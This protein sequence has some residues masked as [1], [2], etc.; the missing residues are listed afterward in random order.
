MIIL[1]AFLIGVVWILWNAA[2][3][4][5]LAL[6]RHTSS[7]AVSVL[8]PLRNEEKRVPL[9]IASLQQL[10]YDQLEIL[11][12]DDDS[13]DA[14]AAR[15]QVAIQDDSRFHLLRGTSLPTGWKGKP[16]ACLQLAKTARGDILLFI[17]ADVTLAHNT[18]EAL[19]AT[20]ARLQADA[21]S[22]FPRFI[23]DSFLENVLTPL[24]HFFIY[25]HL[26]IRVANA[27]TFPA[28]TA[29]SGA[30][31]AMTKDCYF[32]IGGHEVVKSTIVEDMTIVREVKKQGHTAVI[33]HIA[34]FVQ[35]HMYGT[36][37]ATWRGFSKNCFEA[38]G[39][40]YILATG[41]LLFYTAYYTLPAALL[42]YGA[43]SMQWLFVIPYSCIT[44]QRLISDYYSRNIT[45]YSLLMPLSAVCYSALLLVAMY[46][47]F[48][49][50]TNSWKG[51]EL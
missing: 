15:I 34:D 45:L 44:L 10:D 21:L 32:A 29:A 30:F 8:I 19:V 37:R 9:L 31:I 12:Y 50:Q 28:A 1:T 23:N 43:I 48:T 11:L 24:L 25:M 26:P 20:M 7:P 39:N 47:R 40:S 17:D 41:V 3:M 2:Q 46:K 18:I 38:F 5:Q 6:G 13:T 51:R 14:T 16:H 35:C 49:R 42:V 27:Q 36:S 33:V 22:G 4:P